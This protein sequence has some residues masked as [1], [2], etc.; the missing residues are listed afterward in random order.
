MQKKIVCILLISCGVIVGQEGPLTGFPALPPTNAMPIQPVATQQP[1]TPPVVEQPPMVTQPVPPTV[2]ATPT[3]EVT[4]S[5]MPAQT[6][7]QASVIAAEQ[8]PGEAASTSVPT[9]PEQPMPAEP[10]PMPETPESDE[11]EIKG[12]D[13][14]DI[15]EPKGNWLYKRIWWEKAEHLYEK[16]K[17]LADKIMEAR[18]VF[19]ARRHELDHTVLDPFYLTLGLEKGQL[20]EMISYFAEQ[21]KQKN[22]RCEGLDEKERAFLEIIEQ[23]KKTLEHL[24]EQSQ[25]VLK[26]DQAIED[27]LMKLIE[28]LNQARHYEQQAWNNFK[29]INRELSDKR[30][31]ELFYGMDTYWKN[32]NS[33]NTYI[34][35]AFTQYFE[36][37]VTKV[38]Q[39]VESI[40]TT[41]QGLQEKG[42]DIR[43]QA[44][45][46]KSAECK[47]PIKEEEAPEEV[48][49]GIL[50][51]VW[52][53][54]KAPFVAVGSGVSGIFDWVTSFFGGSSEEEVVLAKRSTPKTPAE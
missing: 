27:A 45:K 29:A 16:I 22:E 24:K 49:T 50:G 47:L 5:A 32:L 25:T 52:S 31:R 30:A 18:V 41:I 53:W 23:E 6:P 33:I 11:L 12:I 35:D 39:E 40:K 44:E 10:M 54:I 26:I 7:V 34:S 3:Q 13:T 15:N 9:A 19:F 36:Q 17:E 38:Q 51:T 37:L 2:Q 42:I 28:Q 14:V 48:P 1:V 8:P 21:L 20:E 46:M 43:V 4:P